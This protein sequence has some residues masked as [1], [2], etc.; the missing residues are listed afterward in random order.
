MS[1]LHLRTNLQQL[2]LKFPQT[3]EGKKKKKGRSRSAEKK[4][5]SFYKL[6]WSADNRK[7]NKKMSGFLKRNKERNPCSR[8]VFKETTSDNTRAEFPDEAL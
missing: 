8:I 6:V 3:S 7:S 2:H 1:G 5:Q 4:N